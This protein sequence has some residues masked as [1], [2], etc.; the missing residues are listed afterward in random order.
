M[1][2]R[3]I[4][5]AFCPDQVGITARLTQF[6]ASH[7]GWIVESRQHTEQEAGYF[8][9]R[10]EIRA[11]S[12][13]LEL[14]ELR[15]AFEPIA[16]QLDLHWSIH[17]TAI[18]HKAV[19]LVSQHDHCLADLLYRWRSG[20]LD[21]DIPCVISNHETLRE[22]VEWHG[23]PFY[24][25]PVNKEN[26]AE[27]FAEITDIFTRSAADTMVLARYMQIIPEQMCAQ[28]AGRIINIHHS[29][30]P[31]FAGGKPYL[32]AYQRGVKLVGATCHYVTAVL[33]DGPIIEQDVIRVDHSHNAEDMQRLGRDVERRV[34]ARGL[35]L[36]VQ[37]RIMLHGRRTVVLD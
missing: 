27:A 20:E 15:R 13:D 29:F 19:I 25:V 10:I 30:L 31:S 16:E 9:V 34:L 37:R 18:K 32:Q 26:K 8:F 17:D 2:Q 35:R 11:N 5:T 36:H 12:I 28:F 14:G 21:I 24:Y 4:L 7:G 22:F 6:I 1:D 33:D 23:I 3:Y